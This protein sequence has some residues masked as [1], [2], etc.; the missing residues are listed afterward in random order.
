[1]KLC[2]SSVIIT[3]ISPFFVYGRLSLVPSE[4]LG[5]RHAA[6]LGS[7]KQLSVVII[8]KNASVLCL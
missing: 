3:F 4:K 6:L 1:M 8:R 7:I 5:F 2:G